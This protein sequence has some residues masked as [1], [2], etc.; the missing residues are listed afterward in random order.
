MFFFVCKLHNIVA[1][2]N[3]FVWFEMRKCSKIGLLL[4][5]F[6]FFLFFFLF[7]F[8]FVLA[9]MMAQFKGFFINLPNFLHCCIA[10]SCCGR[11][12]HLKGYFTNVQQFF[13]CELKQFSCENEL[14]ILKKC[15]IQ[16]A[17]LHRDVRS[18]KVTWWKGNTFSASWFHQSL[19]VNSLFHIKTETF[20]IW[21]C[22]F[23]CSCEFTVFFFCFV[24][25]QF[26]LLNMF[27]SAAYPRLR[28]LL[29]Q[30]A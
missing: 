18:W 28:S 16:T 15:F 2:F 22:D 27:C 13:I 14:Y 10:F 29:L 26:P 19:D 21:S 23:R 9:W 4:F 12:A 20:H 7:Y 11:R 3:V 8:P 24:F 6:F 17:Y 1:V 25:F 5:L 30:W